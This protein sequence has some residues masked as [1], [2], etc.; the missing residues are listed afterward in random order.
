MS[1]CR[2]LIKA[3]KCIGVERFV[4]SA[5]KVARLFVIAVPA[6][7]FTSDKEFKVENLPVNTLEWTLAVQVS[8]LVI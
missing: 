3:S 4:T 1:V 6:L 5:G 7:T 8:L 2:V